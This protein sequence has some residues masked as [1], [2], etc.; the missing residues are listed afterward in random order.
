M[1]RNPASAYGEIREFRRVGGHFEFF[2]LLDVEQMVR[3]ARIEGATLET[4]EIRDIILVLDRAAEW[5]QITLSPPATMKT[6][7]ESVA[8]LSLQVADFSEFLRGFRNKILPDGTLDD[9]ASP[10]LARIRRESRGNAARFKTLCAAISVA[11]P[12]AAP[13]KMRSSPSA[14][15]ASSSPSKSSR[16][17]GYRAWSTAP[18][19]AAKPS[20][21][22]P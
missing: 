17:V 3:E 2:G 14:A 1:D 21:S 13:L 9:R 5:R 12:T 4:G 16:S 6:P 19:P 15:S 18:V 7:F 22:N 11:S 10:E 20:S 8:E